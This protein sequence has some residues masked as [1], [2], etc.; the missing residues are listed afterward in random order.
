MRMAVPH[1]IRA[2][3]FVTVPASS[4][5]SH[6]Q[7]PHPANAERSLD[8]R[9]AQRVARQADRM[10]RTL[11]AARRSPAPASRAPPGAQT[12]GGGSQAWQG[13][14][15][16]GPGSLQDAAWVED[17]PDAGDLDAPDDEP[18][19]DSDEERGCG[20]GFAGGSSEQGAAGAA[21]VDQGGVARAAAAQL[22]PGGRDD[23][24]LGAL[25]AA[26]YPDR[27][28]QR[29]ERG[30]RC[31]VAW[32]Q[33]GCLVALSCCGGLARPRRAAPQARDTGAPRPCVRGALVHG[34][35]RHVLL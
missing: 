23:G 11:S 24:A 26:A 12:A 22:F 6:L 33:D 25:V 32:A 14:G 35:T 16:S 34:P 30:N 8:V 13:L 20:R 7:E 27:V 15:G 4:H 31:A 1:C 9:A 28:A 29:R 17:G 19:Y 5:A 10:F 2:P 3:H 18:A 21:D